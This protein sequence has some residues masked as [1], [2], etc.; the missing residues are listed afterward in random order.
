LAA[1]E[2]WCMWAIGVA[3]EIDHGEQDLG[4]VLQ[5]HRLAAVR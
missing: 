3:E 2:F 5:R 4:A 1:A